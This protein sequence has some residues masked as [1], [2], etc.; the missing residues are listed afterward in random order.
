MGLGGSKAERTQD[1]LRLSMALKGSTRG[2][3]SPPEEVRSSRMY[4]TNA[5]AGSVR[6][7][8]ARLW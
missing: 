4:D 8:L 5:G 7:K 1:K 2:I 6:R 3:A